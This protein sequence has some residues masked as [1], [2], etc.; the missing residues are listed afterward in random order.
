[1]IRDSAQAIDPAS[2]IPSEPVTVVLSEKGWVRAAKGHDVDS[3]MGIWHQLWGVVINLSTFWIQ[4]VEVI[5]C[6]QIRF[7]QHAGKV[8]H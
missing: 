7:H 2:L 6:R 3:E 5:L 1:V 8:N 4:L